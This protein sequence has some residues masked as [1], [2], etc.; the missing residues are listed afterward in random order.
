MV[1]LIFYVC[2][3]LGVSFLCSIME[4]VLLSVTPAYI[5][6]KNQAGSPAGRRLSK[7]KDNIDRPL[8]AILSLNTIAHTVGAVGAG[9]QAAIVFG[10]AYIGIASAV[11][12]LLI[13]IVSEIIP[14]TLGAVYWRELAPFVANLLE[15]LVWILSPL[16]FVSQAIT[17]LLARDNEER[18]IQPEEISAMAALGEQQGVLDDSESSVLK[19]T[20][21]LRELKVEDV[22]TPRTV[23]FSLAENKLIDEVMNEFEDLEFSRIPVYSDHEENL[24]GY[25][26]KDE[27]LLRAARN[28]GSTKLAEIKREFLAVSEDEPLTNMLE[29]LIRGPGIIAY[30]VDRYGGLSGIVSLEDVVETLLGLEIVDE[31]DSV[32]DLQQLARE[33]ALRRNQSTTRDDQTND[34]EKKGQPL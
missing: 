14:K 17:R 26:L 18:F 13:L 25:V 33:Q 27:I 10:R 4:A 11:L 23:I 22:M 16:V 24:S 8:A 28:Q 9:A 29:N 30:V 6:N 31:S 15:P 5:E 1:L 32:E 21:R 12:T 20:L 3:A 19:N 7:F 34:F 2:L